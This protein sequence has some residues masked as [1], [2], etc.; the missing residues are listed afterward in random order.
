MEN[1]DMN[2]GAEWLAAYERNPALQL[3]KTAMSSTIVLRSLFPMQPSHAEAWLR[4]STELHHLLFG[5]LIRSPEGDEA[6]DGEAVLSSA[7]ELGIRFHTRQFM[8]AVFSHS[9]G[10]AK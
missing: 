9:V 5:V 1:Y 6:M 10:V 2:D 7:Q 8:E 4:C 3:S